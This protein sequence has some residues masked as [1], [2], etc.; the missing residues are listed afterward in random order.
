MNRPQISRK[1]Y[2]LRA[3]G[4]SPDA[5]SAAPRRGA[6]LIAAIAVVV[7]FPAVVE[8]QWMGRQTGCAQPEIVANPNRPTVANPA[9]IT[10]YGILELEYGWERA[11]PG[12]GA[13]V[14]DTPGLLKFGLLCDIELR[15]NST[16]Y[17]WQEEPTGAAQGIGDNL[18]GAQVRFYKQTRRVPSLAVSYSGKFPSASA[19]K[20]LGS[21]Q[22]DHSITLLASKD[23]LGTHFDVNAT[24]FLIGRTSASGYDRNAQ[25]NFSLS[26]PI[27][28]KLGFTAELYGN[29]RLNA[30]TPGF[31]SLLAALTCNLSPRLVIDGGLDTGLT[32]GAV[33]RR[34]FAG[35]TFS[36]ARLYP[37]PKKKPAVP[38]PKP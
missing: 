29:T 10:Q 4:V 14:N 35:L 21:G 37:A 11:W 25:F 26:H 22:V 6:A 9:D 15:W 18:F 23:V 7:L 31:T 34:A 12:A 20:G 30:T 13:N 32:P 27:R 1:K 36:I 3:H 16:S 17:I 8:A 38:P 2:N 33:R 5:Q 19:T 28:G 24:F